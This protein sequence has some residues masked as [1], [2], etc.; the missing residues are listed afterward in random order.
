VE[1]KTH[2]THA[3]NTK[4]IMVGLGVAAISGWA[5][6]MAIGQNDQNPE[7]VNVLAFIVVTSGFG[8][9]I[10]SSLRAF[11]IQCPTCKKLLTKQVS[12]NKSTETRKF[13]CKRCNVIWDSKVQYEFGGD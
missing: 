13:C 8:I 6:A 2:P 3:R 1:I 11:L 9:I 5:I 7:I 10:L 4:N 12:V